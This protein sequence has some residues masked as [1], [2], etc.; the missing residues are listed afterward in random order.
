M[1]EIVN[2]LTGIIP[3]KYLSLLTALF[4]AS[5]VLG[6][7]LQAIRLGG[8][9]RSIVLGIWFGTNT[10]TG[11][12]EV[13]EIIRQGPDDGHVSGINKLPLFLLF[14]ALVFSLTFATGCKTA[15]LEPGG[16]YAPTNAVGQVVYNNAGL[17]L[18]D[19]SYMFAYETIQGVFKFE[20][21]N[22][23]QIWA[24]SPS[25]K[26]SLDD[27]RPDVVAIDRRWAE[28]RKL[29]KANPT[30]A[31]LSVVQSIISEIERLLPVVQQQLEPVYKNLTNQP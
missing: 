11:K 4:V 24:I 1:E 21:D 13:T 5:Q 17:A 12:Q 26:H 14:G 20:R 18:A 6:R 23:L 19:A 30:P 2:Q 22:R 9:L 8:G 10:K 28:A 25:V 27:I 29:Y 31:G 16:V 3:P 7:I 15:K